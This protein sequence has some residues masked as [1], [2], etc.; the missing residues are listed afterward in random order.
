MVT[1]PSPRANTGEG[2][3]LWAWVVWPCVFFSASRNIL[4]TYVLPGLPALAIL[5]AA[6]LARDTRY[7][8]RARLVSLGLLVTAALFVG[9]T[10]K[11]AADDRVKSA[12]E[13]IAA[14]SVG[15]Y[16]HGR[17]K[18]LSDFEALANRLDPSAALSP[19][20]GRR[21]VALRRWETH[22]PAALR[23][24][25]QHVAFHQGYELLE[26]VR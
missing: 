14:F 12:K 6:W 9:V 1:S 8:R 19:G 5:G 4:W 20:G 21:F 18:P 13:V 26:V 15:F 23:A 22:P 17:Y 10:T 7:Q 16:G 3:Y 25:M 2:L 24:R 11:R